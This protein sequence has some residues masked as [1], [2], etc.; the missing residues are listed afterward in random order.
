[1]LIVRGVNVF[2]AAIREIVAR[3]APRVT[4][5]IEVR[6]RLRAVKQD[7][8]LPIVVE[9][10]EGA[11]PD[12]VL[13]DAIAAEI[14]ATLIFSPEIRFVAARTLPRSEYKSKLVSFA[15]ADS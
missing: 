7:P 9:L 11:Q 2:P 1:M 3:F 5:A 6:P 4:G 15:E 12:P 14:R 10:A 8:P 13:G